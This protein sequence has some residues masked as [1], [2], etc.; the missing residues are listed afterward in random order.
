MNYSS[1][2]LIF[3]KR[4]RRKEGREGEGGKRSGEGKK[5]WVGVERDT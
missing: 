5:E 1:I 2:R 3:K 4:D